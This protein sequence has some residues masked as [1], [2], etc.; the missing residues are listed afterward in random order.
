M[1]M[2]YFN[3]TQTSVKALLASSAA[4]PKKFARDSKG[5]AAIE[6]ALIAPVMIAF[7]FGLSEISMGISADRQVTHATSVAGDLAT[8]VTSLDKDGVEDVMTAAIAVLGVNSSK[9]G[10]VSIELNS[11]KKN[12]DDSIETV[13]HAILGADMPTKFDPSKLGANML[14]STSGVVVARLSYKYKPPTLAFMSEVTLSETF[15]LKPRK[16]L[17]VAFDESGK[18]KFKCKA[19]KDYKVSCS[20]S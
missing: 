15:L 9:L 1:M 8:Q 2:T 3:T 16:S 6:F 17:S 12:P 5:V 10:R 11:Y 13:G 14:N 19:G 20:A 4:L 18:T 7:Y